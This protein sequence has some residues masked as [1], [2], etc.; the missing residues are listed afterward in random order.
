MI[1]HIAEKVREGVHRTNYT[2]PELGVQLVR[3]L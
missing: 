2:G 1:N 3:K